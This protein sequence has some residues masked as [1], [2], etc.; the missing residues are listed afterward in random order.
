MIIRLRH[1]RDWEATG[2]GVD[3]QI[4]LLTL[5]AWSAQSAGHTLAHEVGHC[6]QYQV[7]CDNGDQNGWMYGYGTN[8]AGGNGWWEQCAQWQGF[9]IFP[10]Q[11]FTDGR[12]ANYLNTAHKHILHETPRYDNY[13]IQDYWTYRRGMD[14]IGRLWNESK[15]PED[16]VD[17]YKRINSVTQSEFNDEMYDCAARFATW[18]IPD[19]IEYGNSRYSARPQTSLTDIGDD[20]WQINYDHCPENYGY[21]IIK[22]NAPSSARTVSVLFEGKPGLTGYRK[23]SISY[24]GWRF[25]FVALLKDGTRVYSEMGSA[26]FRAQQGTV[27]FDCPG[28]SIQRPQ[29]RN[30]IRKPES[31]AAAKDS[32]K[33]SSVS[34]FPL[35]IKQLDARSHPAQLLFSFVH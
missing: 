34:L 17:T 3:D 7:H 11:Q 23:K 33:S 1:T 10:T 20:V 8:G 5:T 27:V 31:K 19:L 12:Y 32:S 30:S 21:N 2:S 25:G 16:P 35:F 22:L 9:K 24:A 18:D 13:F 14:I 29:S 15:Y 6:F 26:S 4:G 28:A